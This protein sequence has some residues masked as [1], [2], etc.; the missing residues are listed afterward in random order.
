M[1]PTSMACCGIDRGTITSTTGFII[2]NGTGAMVPRISS[3]LVGEFGDMDTESIPESN[4]VPAFFIVEMMIAAVMSG[5]LRSGGIR[6][7]TVLLLFQRRV[8]PR[9]TAD[10]RT[11]GHGANTRIMAMVVAGIPNPPNQGA[12]GGEIRITRD[13]ADLAI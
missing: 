8:V 3:I 7:A 11:R 2:S 4:E 5:V 12:R 6:I 13:R 1:G 10:R 9:S